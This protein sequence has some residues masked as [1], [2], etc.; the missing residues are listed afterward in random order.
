ML[1]LDRLDETALHTHAAKCSA[2]AGFD[3][4]LLDGRYQDAA[5]GR[6]AVD[7]GAAAGSGRNPDAVVRLTRHLRHDSRRASCL[8]SAPGPIGRMS[9]PVTLRSACTM[10]EALGHEMLGHE[11]L[12]NEILDNETWHTSPDGQVL[13][14]VPSL[15][16]IVC[17]YGGYV[18][19]L[20]MHRSAGGRQ[21]RE[22]MLASGT[23][24]TVSAA[25]LAAKQAA[26]RI[27]CMLDERKKQ[28]SVSGNSTLQPAPE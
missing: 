6:V 1:F 24:S 15:R 22:T 13:A 23:E 17:N 27:A 18:R 5:T 20:I 16:L 14:T 26:A 11:M 7:Y 9:F 12:G 28:R 21:A 4:G 3:E 10:H 2:Q 19:Y 25:I 8:P